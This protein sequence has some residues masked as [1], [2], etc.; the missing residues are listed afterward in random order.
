[1]LVVLDFEMP[2]RCGLST[3]RCIRDREC[4][5][6][7]RVPIIVISAHPVI[8]VLEQFCGLGIDGFIEKP[9]LPSLLLAWIQARLDL[10]HFV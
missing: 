6:G 7:T 10:R 3:A 5:S 9:C 2:V 4:G 8:D 1:M